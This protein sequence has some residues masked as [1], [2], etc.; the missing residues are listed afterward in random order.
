ML[1]RNDFPFVDSIEDARLMVS[2]MEDAY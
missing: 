2:Q 1:G